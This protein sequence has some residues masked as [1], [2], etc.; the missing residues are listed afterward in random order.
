MGYRKYIGVFLIILLAIVVSRNLIITGNIMG[1]QTIIKIGLLNA[2]STYCPLEYQIDCALVYSKLNDDTWHGISLASFSFSDRFHIETIFNNDSD[3]NS[4]INHFIDSDVKAIYIVDMLKV[5]EISNSEILISYPGNMFS[6][7]EPDGYMFAL[8]D[9]FL[10]PMLIM[11]DV[12]NNYGVNKTGIVYVK[13]PLKLDNNAFDYSNEFSNHIFNRAVDEIAFNTTYY[14]ENRSN[15]TEIINLINSTKPEAIAFL[16][17]GTYYNEFSELLSELSNIEYIKNVNMFSIGMGSRKSMPYNISDFFEN[18][19]DF[20]IVKN[21]YIPEKIWRRWKESPAQD[22]VLT[23]RTTAIHIENKE[24]IHLDMVEDE[25]FLSENYVTPYISRN[26]Q[27]SYP[28]TVEGYAFIEIFRDLLGMCG[29]DTN[30]IKE[31]IYGNAFYTILGKVRF[32][33]NGSIIR[34]YLLKRVDE[35]LVGITIVKRYTLSDIENMFNIYN[36]D[37]LN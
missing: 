11:A 24:D 8:Q 2:D 33:K 7:S 19:K 4:S 9:Q 23:S 25:M 1:E 34:P 5:L 29:D 36:L 6:F 31:N 12:M 16:G 30:C 26:Q 27:V 21:D 18:F 15:I 32:R 28:Y 3:L 35:S 14:T 17:Y 37:F 13:S 22:L 10:I 20:F